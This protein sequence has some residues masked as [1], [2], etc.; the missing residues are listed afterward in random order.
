M[1]SYAEMKRKYLVQLSSAVFPLDARGM[2][3]ATPVLEK[4]RDEG[5]TEIACINECEQPCD[6][7]D[8]DKAW[9][10]TDH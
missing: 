6:C 10:L 8:S 1:A 5:L 9:Q 3:K 2:K 4:M 7:P